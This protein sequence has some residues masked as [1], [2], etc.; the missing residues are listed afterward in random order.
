MRVL[1]IEEIERG[2]F[3][4]GSIKRA[5]RLWRNISI[6][7]QSERRVAFTVWDR[8]K[9]S[10]HSVIYNSVKREPADWSCDCKWY[11]TQGIGSGKYCAHILAVHLFLNKVS[12]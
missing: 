4:R 10:K 2:G 1:S 6:D 12:Q 7:Y 5:R 8:E 3:A 11:S 9:G